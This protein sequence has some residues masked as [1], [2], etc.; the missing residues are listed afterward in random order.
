MVLYTFLLYLFFYFTDSCLAWA[1][2]IKA[3]AYDERVMGKNVLHYSQ[4]LQIN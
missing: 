1:S 2:L 4:P 3:I